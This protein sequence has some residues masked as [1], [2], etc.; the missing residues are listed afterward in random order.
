MKMK[1]IKSDKNR[2]KKLNESKKEKK[3]LKLDKLSEVESFSLKI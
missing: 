2:K 3:K 1:K